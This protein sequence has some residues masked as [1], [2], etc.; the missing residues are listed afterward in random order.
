MESSTK[1][2][3]WNVKG[4]GHVIKRKK[5]LTF[6]KKEKV[7][8]AML[9]ETHLSDSEHLKLKRDWVGQ[10]Y[11]SS[12]INNPRKRG[13]TI[14]SWR[15][16]NPTT[17]DYTFYSNPHCSYSRIDYIFIPNTYFN[18]ASFSQIGSIT[19]SDHAPVQLD[20]KLEIPKT[21]NKT[22]KLNSSLL[23]DHKFCN[24]VRE[25]IQNYWSDNKN[26]NAII[27]N[28]F[29][30]Y[31]ESLYRSQGSASQLQI[32][33]F[34]NNISLPIISDKDRDYLNSPI[35]PEEVLAAIQS[36]SS[37]KSPGPDGFPSEFYKSFWPELSNILVPALQNILD[38]GTIPETW[39]TANICVILKKDKD[40]QDCASFRP[41]SLLNTDSKI[42]AKVLACRLESMLPKLIKPDQTGFIKSRYGTDN[43]RRLLN[44]INFVQ[45][46]GHPALVLSLDAD[47]AFDRV[48]WDFLF[49]T[50]DKFNLGNNFIKWI[51]LLYSDPKAT[52]VTNGLASTPFRIG[53]GMRQGCP[54][55][56]LL[57]ALVIEPLAE[58]IRQNRNFHGILIGGEDHR[59]SLYAD[60][61]LIFMSKP[62]QSIPTL[63]EC[64]SQIH[65]FTLKHPFFGTFK[66]NLPIQIIRNW[67]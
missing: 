13:T 62:E 18:L 41:I 7:K 51:Q 8:V 29:R 42:L 64:I 24:I 28:T 54:L 4:L 60:D 11:Y 53:R 56:P 22:W 15:E 27:N 10:V 63:L 55:S 37:N 23:S 67:F 20:I 58:L 32:Q 19:I 40:P 39:K 35:T 16:L 48:E 49:A 33:T 57:F 59:T 31:Y 1:F 26:S 34:F 17:R 61:V 65:S 44:V 14:L 38:Q 12:C 21:N 46:E 9:Q 25:S 36:M 5:V 43:I 45:G 52:V 66:I 47:K 6:L 3:T 2:I 50:L 30:S